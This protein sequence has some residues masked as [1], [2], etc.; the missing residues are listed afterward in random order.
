MRPLNVAGPAGA[1]VGIAA[2][3]NGQAE[4]AG[5]TVAVFTTG[6]NIDPERF[7]SLVNTTA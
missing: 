6:G 3:L 4:I 5:K 1:A 7:C 2:I